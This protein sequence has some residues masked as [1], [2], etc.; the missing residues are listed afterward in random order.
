MSII[1]ITQRISI[2]KGQWAG[3][4]CRRIDNRWVKRVLEWRPCFG[5][6]NVERSPVIWGDD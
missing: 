3:H 5:K 2:L 1:D 4:I 6:R